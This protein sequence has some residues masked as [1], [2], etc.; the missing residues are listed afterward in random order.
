LISTTGF[1]CVSCFLQSGPD[2]VFPY[3]VFD[4]TVAHQ[5]LAPP[6]SCFLYSFVFVFHLSSQWSGQIPRS[7]RILLLRSGD[8]PSPQHVASALLPL[9]FFVQL[10]SGSVATRSERLSLG[11]IT[12]IPG[13]LHPESRTRIARTEFSSP[14]DRSVSS[15]AF[16]FLLAPSIVGYCDVRSL[17][18]DSPG[19][20]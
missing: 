15:S 2:L 8:F 5:V 19:C 12:H 9:W 18:I 17:F 1:G 11:A 13:T 14:P 16:V 20:M 4:S 3:L 10:V 7:A 6:S